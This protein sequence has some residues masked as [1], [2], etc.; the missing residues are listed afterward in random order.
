MATADP[1]TLDHAFERYCSTSRG[2]AVRPAFISALLN[3][4]SAKVATQAIVGSDGN[5]ARSSRQ[6]LCYWQLTAWL[7]RQREAADADAP[8]SLNVCEVGFNAGHSAAIFLLALNH[9]RSRYYGFELPSCRFLNKA[10]PLLNRSLF[11]GQLRMTLGESNHSVPAFF[12]AHPEVNCDVVSIDGNHQILYVKA[13]WH[14]LK[15]RLA[16][17]GIVLLDDVPFWSRVFRRGTAIYEPELH[18]VGCVSLPG[19]ADDEESLVARRPVI[20]SDGFCVARRTTT[21]DALHTWTLTRPDARIQ[22]EVTR[23]NRPEAAGSGAIR[24]PA[25]G[26]RHSADSHSASHSDRRKKAHP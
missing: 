23:F 10:V 15:S 17:G 13:D 9:S 25:H 6:I 18:L 24:I 22:G 8:P 12:A 26:L 2:P 21:D 11:P 19:R 4:I 14:N 3:D 1:T 16:P 7:R 20:A 5:V